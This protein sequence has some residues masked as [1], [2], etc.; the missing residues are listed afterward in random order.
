MFTGR[1]VSDDNNSSAFT[2]SLHGTHLQSLQDGPGHTPSKLRGDY[3]ELNFYL[4]DS[5]ADLEFSGQSQAVIFDL[6][7]SRALPFH[8]VAQ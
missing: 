7:H 5:E 1:Y 2:I 6:R 4:S 8:R 3:G